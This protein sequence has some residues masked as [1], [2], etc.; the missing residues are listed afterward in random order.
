M[1]TLQFR[2]SSDHRIFLNCTK[3]MQIEKCI[4]VCLYYLQ[5]ASIGLGALSDI[6][7]TMYII[8]VSIQRF[9]LE[10]LNMPK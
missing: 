8:L 10:P 1:T 4:K 6:H 7:A 9:F 2:D 3:I 5:W